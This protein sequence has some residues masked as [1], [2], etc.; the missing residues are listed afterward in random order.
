MRPNTLGN[1][2]LGLGVASAALVFGIGF[3]AL[4]GTRQ[5]WIGALAIPLLVCGVSSAFLGLLGA[6]LGVGGLF[7]NQGT[8][9]TAVAGLLLSLLGLCLFLLFLNV[10]GRGG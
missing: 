7:G 5:G 4:L 2:S 1:T 10:I 8:K 3:C 6:G 9:S